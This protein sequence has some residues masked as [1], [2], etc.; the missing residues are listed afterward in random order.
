MTTHALEL[1]L[2]DL[3]VKRP[4]RTAFAEDAAVFLGRYKLDAEEVEMV[5]TFDVAA[6]QRRGVSALL[7][8]G[9][10]MMNEPGKSRI[11]YLKRLNSST[12]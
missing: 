8:L 3:G 2:H 9:F 10:W 5:R 4:A 6:L 11:E 12:N 1:V 7:T